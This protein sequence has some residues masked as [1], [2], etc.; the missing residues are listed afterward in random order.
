MLLVL[1]SLGFQNNKPH[2]TKWVVIKGCSLQ[3]DGSTNVNK[4]S[5]KI[6]NYSHP[7]TII[8]TSDVNQQVQLKGSIRL[9]VQ[10]FDCHNP[11]MTADLRKTLKAKEFP[12][13]IIYFVSMGRYPGV[14][15]SN[16]LIKGTVI[17]SL[18]GVSKRLEVDYKV[19]TAQ[20]NN[21]TVIGSRKIN[22]S[23]FDIKPPRKLGGMIQT[24]NELSVV[25]TLKI[26]ELD[27]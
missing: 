6:I 1:V 19:I 27:K 8:V 15:S 10:K 2:V 18:A 5:C 9:D 12:K 21:I 11:I 23:D 4:F 14:A 7:D 16:D 13:L 17:I 22:F 20:T 26:K 24:N 25:F 3:V